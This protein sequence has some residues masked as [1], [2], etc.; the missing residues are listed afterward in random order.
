MPMPA[1]TNTEVA[2]F[3]TR[4][5]EL[6]QLNGDNAFRIRALANGA[7]MIEELDVD[8]VEL[9]RQETL[10][11]IEGVG[12]GIAE[13]VAEFID[14]GTTRTYEELKQVVP[15]GLLDLLRLPGLGHKK[16]MAIHEALQI[17]SVAELEDACGSG[18]LDA[19][20]GFGG[21]TSQR[22]LASI[23]RSRTRVGRF[24]LGDALAEAEQLCDAVRQRP[25]TI[26]VEIA[27]SVRR[28]R[29]TVRD[30]DLVASSEHPTDLAQA[31]ATMPMVSQILLQGPTKTTV[32][33]TSGLQADLRVVSDEEYPLLLHHL[34]GS[35]D[36]NVLMR[37]RALTMGLPFERIQP[38]QGG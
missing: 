21:K 11:E 35:K 1:P 19:L 22:L 36:H 23:A 28:Y 34:T 27:G 29:E 33:L 38:G 37:S 25:E 6:M 32:R 5:S 31:F 30:I 10:T 18:A 15:E 17:T 7:R 3:L 8:V 24:R 2:S 9:S 26:R 12:K 14:S 4:L 16:V 13:S 20:P